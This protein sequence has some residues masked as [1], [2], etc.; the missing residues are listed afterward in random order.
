MD[1]VKISEIF[2]KLSSSIK[3]SEAKPEGKYGVYGAQGLLGF[4]DTYQTDKESI[5]VIKDGAGIGRVQIIPSYSSVIGTM[6][7]LVPIDGID[8]NYAFF[9]LTYLNLGGS[10]SGATIPHIYFKNYGRIDTRFRNH[11]EQIQI[12]CSLS[13]IRKCQNDAGNEILLL[14]SLVKSRF[15][16]QEARSCY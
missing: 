13:E 1:S 11:S 8:I 15:V 3:A 4:L 10:F 6:Q 9:L 7:L 14:D 12:G 16:N 5:A 2:I